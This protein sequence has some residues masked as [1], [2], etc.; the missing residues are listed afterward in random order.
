ME[1]KNPA[2]I[3]SNPANLMATFLPFPLAIHRLIEIVPGDTCVRNETSEC[4]AEGNRLK[5]FYEFYM[6]LFRPDRVVVSSSL[7][8][9]DG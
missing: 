1:S 9:Y 6:Y 2:G 7:S 3:T 5:C 4:N 8:A